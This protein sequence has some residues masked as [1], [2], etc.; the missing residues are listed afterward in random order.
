MPFKEKIENQ[1]RK[2]EQ[3]I[4]QILS[5]KWCRYFIGL[6][7]FLGTSSII[8]QSFDTDKEYNTSFQTISFFC[9]FIFTIEYALRLFS[10]P[11]D[12][13]GINPLKARLIYIISFM[14]IIDFF[15]ILPFTIIYHPT[16]R[17]YKEIIEL[18][19]IFIIFKAFRYTTSYKVIKE[20]VSSVKYELF[21]AF[22]M[23]TII[24]SFCA[25]LMYYIEREAQPDAFRNIGEGF[26]WAI[27]TFT[28]VGYGDIYPVTT[29]GKV[30]AS[31]M[32]TIGVM[33]LSLP[34][35]II[36]GSFVEYLQNQKNQKKKQ[37]ENS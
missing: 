34:T 4:S 8:L 6:I 1:F 29:L 9:A 35:A 33:T 5:A 30:L 12:Y 11:A 22:S 3:N 31:V 16:I 23:S 32:A 7:I 36:S 2:K 27:I 19:K 10:A 14:G 15:S 20:V 21:V 37:V 13:P 17:D 26:W 24:I 28:S 18:G 25:I